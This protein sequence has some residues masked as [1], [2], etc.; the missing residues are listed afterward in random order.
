MSRVVFFGRILPERYPISLGQS[1]SATVTSPLFR[2]SVTHNTF[3]HAGQIVMTLT[4]HDDEQ[5]DRLTLRNLALEIAQAVIDLFSYR[6]GANYEVEILSMVVEGTDD[7]FVFGPEIGSVQD[8]R[9]GSSPEV[10]FDL[11]NAVTSRGGPQIVLKNFRSAMRDAAGTGFY[12]YRAIE[13]MRQDMREAGDDEHRSWQRLRDALNISR[14]AIDVVKA[15][16]D[17]PRHGKP[18]SITDSERKTVFDVT[19]EVIRR[20]LAYLVGGRT[21]LSAASFPTLQP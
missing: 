20:Y 4:L 13:A 9:A 7:K 18:N 17:D 2:Y 21:P 12:C 1:I 16:A 8:R 15:H 6:L 11:L 5:I 3:I 14:A 19:D 10:A